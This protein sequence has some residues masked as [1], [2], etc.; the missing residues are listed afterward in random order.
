MFLLILPPETVA[1]IALPLGH[2]ATPL[3]LDPE[4]LQLMVADLNH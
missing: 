4:V 2:Q 1:Q 3:A